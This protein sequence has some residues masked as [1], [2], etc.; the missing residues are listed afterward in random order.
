MRMIKGL[1]NKSSEERFSE[2]GIFN[3]EKRRLGDDMKAFFK[4]LKGWKIFVLNCF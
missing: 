1:E 2:C 3:L 4:Y